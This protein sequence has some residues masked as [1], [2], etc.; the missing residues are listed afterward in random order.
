[1]SEAN[2]IFNPE[3][4]E[5]DGHVFAFDCG[6]FSG[7]ICR[8]S[9]AGDPVYSSQ[10]RKWLFSVQAGACGYC[11]DDLGDHL[12]AHIEHVIPKVLGGRHCPPNIMLACKACNSAKR[13]RTLDDMR[14]YLRVRHSHIAGIITPKQ[15]LLLEQ[16]GIDLFLPDPKPFAFE[17]GGWWHVSISQEAQL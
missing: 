6:G 10:F 15:A 12:R 1:M 14:H 13:D 5:K 7:R 11:G 16:S 3:I 17:A 4:V 2:L 9:N 8:I